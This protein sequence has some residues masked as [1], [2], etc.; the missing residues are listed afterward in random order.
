MKTI[1]IELIG[2]VDDDMVA[3]F[4][5]RKKE[6]EAAD[7]I[8][9]LINSGGGAVFAGVAIYNLL[10]KVRAKITTEV[11]GIA[12]SA[13]SLVALV[14][15]R[16]IMDQ[17]SFLMI[18]EP[19]SM[20]I[21][22]ADDLGETAIL[23]QRIREEMALIYA[24]RLGIDVDLAIKMM[25][26]ETWLTFDDLQELSFAGELIRGP[27][28]QA[29]ASVYMSRIFEEMEKKGF[30]VPV[31]NSAKKAEEK[32]KKEGDMD[33]IF[34]K[35]MDS[36]TAKID[37]M[38]EVLTT[39]T[40]RVETPMA[41]TSYEVGGPDFVP[42]GKYRLA[43]GRELKSVGDFI[44]YALAHP[45][46]VK[47][48]VSREADATDG[49]P[50]PKAYTEELWRALVSETIITQKAMRFGGTLLTLQAPVLAQDGTAGPGGGYTPTYKAEGAD[51]DISDPKIGEILL[52]PR[53]L[54][55]VTYLSDKILASTSAIEQ[56]ISDFCR[57][58]IF[59]VAE[60]KFLAGSG[61]GEPQGIIGSAATISI[62]RSTANDV[63]AVDLQKMISALTPASRM[64]AFWIFSIDAAQKIYGLL[65]N[66]KGATVLSGP[67][68]FTIFGL[69]VFF[70]ETVPL[71]TS[72][73]VLLVDPQA[74]AIHE[75]LQLQ[76]KVSAEAGFRADSLAVKVGWAHDG[77][78]RVKAPIAWTTGKTV[79]PFVKLT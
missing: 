76:V 11:L 64:R 29:V 1:T 6:L 24:E 59:A 7:E 79:S 14:G 45:G 44:P 39:A 13:A 43:N 61:T 15:D 67:M 38:L 53:R 63:T 16:L 54:G 34:E 73:D 25:A 77:K 57:E 48:L 3:T 36:V 56:T 68:T 49:L 20:T 46:E 27:A 47:A 9:L 23:L 74:Y 17:G 26:E 12:A 71:G 31:K 30:K 72:G 18:H 28:Q 40:D 51:Y 2:E 65:D 10:S 69:P 37:K 52:Q 55:A 41:S 42:G 21:G 58:R 50:I 8:H 32:K 60:K 75:G 62:T 66:A 70:A 22:T 5:K 4:V 35:K 19:W 78:P 33:D